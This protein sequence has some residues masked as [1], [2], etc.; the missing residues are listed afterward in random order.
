M[1]RTTNPDRHLV[2]PGDT[3]GDK[4]SIPGPGTKKVGDRVVA[5]TAGLLQPL[6]E[7]VTVLPM[8]GSYDPR[9]GDQVVGVIRE[10]NPGNWIVDIR[11]P[12]LCPMHVSEVPWRV[13]FGE[14]T[15]YL[16][17]GDAILC[18]V[19]FVDDQKKVQVTLKD[20]NLTKLEGGEII[21]VS[22]VKVARVIGKNGTMLNLIK[23]YVECWMQVGQNGR[24]WVNGE[25][26]EVLLAKEVIDTISREGHLPGLTEKVKELLEK[27]RPGG[28]DAGIKVE[29]TAGLA[30]GRG[31]NA[32]D[33]GAE[34]ARGAAPSNG[35]E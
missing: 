25:P 22:P 4:R 3:V 1:N 7:K 30:S 6:G 9:P 29:R 19:L 20:R 21:E 10:A 2:L 27:R 31:G 24:I 32:G 23:E 35:Q 28:L 34:A 33:G 8:S 14:T 12:W 26:K 11:A 15:S 17:A 5:I 16:K 13:D 18:K